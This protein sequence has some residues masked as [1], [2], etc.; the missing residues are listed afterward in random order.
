MQNAF[1]FYHQSM[2][3]SK[4]HFS[5]WFYYQDQSNFQDHKFE[6]R[7]WWLIDFY[8]PEPCR[9][10]I[11]WLSD[12]KKTE[13]NKPFNLQNKHD[14][15]HIKERLTRKKKM[16]AGLQPALCHCISAANILGLPHRWSKNP[17]TSKERTTQLISWFFLC[18]QNTEFSDFL[19]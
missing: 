15:N 10:S 16:N 8:Q 2:G 17:Y 12:I 6:R 11:E 1:Q 19:F 3:N 5:F 18:S 13:A 9:F 7:N 14:C 4:I